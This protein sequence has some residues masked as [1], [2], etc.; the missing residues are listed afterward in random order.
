M[1][2]GVCNCSGPPRRSERS[3]CCGLDGA[4]RTRRTNL[5][6]IAARLGMPAPE[7]PVVNTMTGLHPVEAAADRHL[8]QRARD[9]SARNRRLLRARYAKDFDLLGYAP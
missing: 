9:L 8:Q 5:C 1:P 7:L 4:W 2:R 3:V 6:A